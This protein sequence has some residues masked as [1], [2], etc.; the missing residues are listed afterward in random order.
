MYV[1][2]DGKLRVTK[3]GADTVLNFSSI[4]KIDFL[5][6]V[7]NR[8]YTWQVLTLPNSR[9]F[10]DYKFIYITFGEIGGDYSHIN[11]TPTF[12]TIDEFKK[13]NTHTIDVGGG[14]YINIKYNT[15][16]TFYVSCGAD[17]YR[18]SFMYGIK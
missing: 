18:H 15:D 10:S 7:E 11:T 13:G 2:T 3:G 12:V 6:G 14:Y 5:W 4:S 9:K 17:S 16:T 1:G 8:N